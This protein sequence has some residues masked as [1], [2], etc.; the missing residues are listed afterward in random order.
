M[1]ERMEVGKGCVFNTDDY[2]YFYFFDMTK[3]IS[4]FGS[5][6]PPVELPWRWPPPPPPPPEF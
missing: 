1:K 3:S 6:R 2:F 4:F 5:S